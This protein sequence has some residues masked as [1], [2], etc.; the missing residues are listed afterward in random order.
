MTPILVVDLEATCSD[1][2]NSPQYREHVVPRHEMEVIEIGAVLCDGRTLAPLREFQTFVKPVRHPLLTRFCQDLTHIR[3]EDVD[4][5]PGFPAA[6]ERLAA[7]LR[8][9]G[10][11][12]GGGC[13][14]GSWGDYDWF[15]LQQDARH[16]RC[17]LPPFL[18]RVNLKQAFADRQGCRPMGMAGALRRA[19]L[20]LQGTHHR[21]I[22]DARNIAALLPWIAEN[23]RAGAG[24][25]DPGRGDPA[26]EARSGRRLP[27]DV[28]PTHPRAQRHHEE[29]RF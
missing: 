27:H 2:S 12:A 3:Q 29:E 17:A 9:A 26:R 1:R 14:F 11:S 22:D 28:R 15:Q 8:D 4:A 23:G 21:G 18:D 16:H 10:L 6:M 24:R 7:F 13:T 25:A 19:G 5:A 20:A